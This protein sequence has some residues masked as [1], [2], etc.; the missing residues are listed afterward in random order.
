MK[1][2]M[3]KINPRY[4]SA[5]IAALLIIPIFICIILGGK[6]GRIFGSIVM[7]IGAGYSSYEFI[8]HMKL[9]KVSKILIPL[10]TISVFLVEKEFVMIHL[11]KEGAGEPGRGYLEYMIGF[12]TIL[13]P[14]IVLTLV[15]FDPIAISEGRIKSYIYVLFITIASGLFFR[16]LFALTVIDWKIVML[17]IPVAIISDTFAYIGGS[18]LG[19]KFPKKLSPK[20]SPKKTWVGFI[21]GYLFAVLYIVLYIHFTGIFKFNNGAF[22]VENSALPQSRYIILF[23]MLA[24]TLPIVSPIGDLVFSSF[25]REMNI[26]DYGKIMPGHGGLLDRIDSWIFIVITFAAILE[27]LMSF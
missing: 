1:N 22:I 13:I 27:M 3:K 8:K 21:T 26:K 10:L 20:I 2:Y 6:G 14:A 7:I 19:K 16:V 9:H 4:P 11:V 12:S 24:L 15:L 5:I 17:L 23:V 18:L 25:K